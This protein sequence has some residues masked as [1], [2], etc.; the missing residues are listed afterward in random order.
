MT[1]TYDKYQLNEAPIIVEELFLDLNWLGALT[2]KRN[3]N[4]QP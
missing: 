1:E 2:W 3:E 4:T